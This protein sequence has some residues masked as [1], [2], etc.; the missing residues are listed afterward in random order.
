[1]AAKFKP[2][3]SI[4]TSAPP[5]RPVDPYLVWGDATDFEYDQF[6]KKVATL[7]VEVDGATSLN[8][9]AKW[10]NSTNWIR[11]PLAYT[12]LMGASGRKLRFCTAHVLTSS[13]S[14]ILKKEDQIGDFWKHVKRYELAASVAPSYSFVDAANAVVNRTGKPADKRVALAQ[15]NAMAGAV[16]SS[17]KTESGKSPRQFL[18]IVDMAIPYA[19][20]SWRDQLRGLWD[21]RDDSSTPKSAFGYGR[22]WVDFSNAIEPVQAVYSVI[23]EVASYHQFGFPLNLVRRTHGAAVVSQATQMSDSVE[24]L[25]VQLPKQALAFTSR[26]ALSASILDACVWMMSIISPSDSLVINLSLGT[27]AGPHDGSSLLESAIDNLIEF[28]RD[29]DVDHVCVVLA[30]GNAYESQAHA[31]VNCTKAKPAVMNWQILPDDVTANFV[32]IWFPKDMDVMKVNPKVTLT[33]PSGKSIGPAGIG[34]FVKFEGDAKK[35]CAMVIFPRRSTGGT[36]LMALVSVAPTL[37]GVAEAGRW[38]IEISVDADLR[39]V[40]AYVERDTSMF[41]PSRPAGRQSYFDDPMYVK[42][43][44]EPG[45]MAD[46]GGSWVRR[47]GTVNSLATGNE[48]IVIGSCFHTGGKQPARYSSAGPSRYGRQDV[49]HASATG[50]DGE[51]LAGINVDGSF[52]G[53]TTRL[54][55]TSVAAPEVARFLASAM[56]SKDWP[57]KH[58]NARAWLTWALSPSGLGG[59]LPEFDAQLGMGRFPRGG[60]N[61]HR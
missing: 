41:D 45:R 32:E 14:K 37:I 50:E 60:F 11:V 36:D 23:D 9:F 29:S 46:D 6:V 39:D 25:A 43:G 58:K 18:G 57:S 13:L 53:S 48:P 34:H 51:T 54:A 4:K 55:G 61:P 8:E 52:S 42:A 30:S 31:I 10:A 49:P 15:L 22:E 19:Q 59:A 33:S 1:M 2:T 38:L 56:I 28:R 5:T 40:N 26:S 3:A 21:Q 7:L 47:S 44:R 17:P 27:H 35:V 12:G 16:R 20:V 24:Y